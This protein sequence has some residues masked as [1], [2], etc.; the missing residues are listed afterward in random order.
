MRAVK[1]KRNDLILLLRLSLTISFCVMYHSM[2]LLAT[3]RFIS[4]FG[5]FPFV[6]SSLRD[7]YYFCCY[8]RMAKCNFFLFRKCITF[9]QKWHRTSQCQFSLNATE[10]Y[11][12]FTA[13]AHT[14]FLH[15]LAVYDQFSDF[16]CLFIFHFFSLMIWHRM[17]NSEVEIRIE[18]KMYNN[19][20]NQNF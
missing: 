12:R 17:V 16:F 18:K 6:L 8:L 3:K 7:F 13:L 19:D 9:Y 2:L 10:N 15:L 20:H 11:T 4:W 5:F 14:H 1:K